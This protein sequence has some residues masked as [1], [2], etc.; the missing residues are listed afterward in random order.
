MDYSGVVGH[1]LIPKN[2][3]EQRFFPGKSWNLHKNTLQLC[4]PGPLQTYLHDVGSIMF[5]HL[6]V[7]VRL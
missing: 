5:A 7:S 4:I 1:T 6:F 2:K 3:L